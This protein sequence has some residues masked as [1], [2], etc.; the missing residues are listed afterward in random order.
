MCFVSTQFFSPSQGW[1]A[2]PVSPSE[3]Q[4]FLPDSFH[5][6]EELGAIENA[7]FNAGPTLIHIQTAHGNYEAQQK[8]R[9]L[10]HFLKQ[11]YGIKTLFIEGSVSKLEPERLRFFPDDMPLTMKISDDLTKK[12][13]VKGPELF[14]L[15]DKDSEAYG[16]ENA[17]IY[18]AGGQ[19]FLAVLTQQQKTNHFVRAVD[20][21]IDRLAGIV[22]NKDLRAFLKR[23]EE[24]DAGRLPVVE[25]LAALKT[26]AAKRLEM[27]LEDPAYQ[28]DWPMLVRIFKLQEIEKKM[29]LAAYE[30]EK[31]EFLN[32]IRRFMGVGASLA[33]ARSS[34]GRGQA[35]PLPSEIESI[36]ST[37]FSHQP[38]PYPQTEILFEKMVSALPPNF[39]YE[40]YPNV[41]FFI[42]HL[43]LQSEIKADF[44][45]KET[46]A[47]ADKISE[48]LAKTPDEKK[49]LTLL[50]NY[51]LL[52]KLFRLE[53]TPR[54]YET[55]VSFSR[56]INIHMGPGQN[57]VIPAKAGI[58]FGDDEN[59]MKP[60]LI[61]NQF[62]NLNSAKRVRDIRFN[63]L[64]EIDS[65]F[66]KA[67]DYYRFVKERDHWMM[68]NIEK[69]MKEKGIEKAIVITGGFHSQPFTDTFTQK[70]YRYALIS[71]KITT[72]DGREAYI[73][74]ALK[75]GFNLQSSTTET[76]SLMDRA[77]RL[78]LA[79]EQA[80]WQIVK[81]DSPAGR[82]IP[83]SFHLFQSSIDHDLAQALGRSRSGRL[84]MHPALRAN[85]VDSRS[86][87]RM[88]NSL[89]HGEKLKELREQLGM[90]QTEFRQ[91]LEPEN[92][93][94]QGAFSNWEKGKTPVSI[95]IMRKAEDLVRAK[96]GDRLK[97][98]REQLGMTQMEF[99][100]A[101][102]PKNPFS[103]ATVSNWERGV[104]P[105][106]IR[107]MR[108]AEGLVRAKSG[109]RLKD[110][111]EQLG[112]N[113]KEL[114][115]ALR[116]ENAYSAKMVSLWEKG[117]NSVSL[118]VMRKTE[119]LVRA[120]SGDR[121][122]EF[123]E[124][125]GM[126]QTEF[127]QALQPENPPENVSQWEKSKRAIPKEIFLKAEKIMLEKSGDHLKA[128]REQLGMNQKEFGRVLRHENPFLPGTISHWEK[129]G[130]LVPVE[131]VRKAEELVRAKS[132]DR[133]K[134]LREQLGMTQPELGQVLRPEN[135][136]SSATISEWERG[137]APVSI[138]IMRKAEELVRAK[139]GD[140]LEEMR[141]Q[142]GM[143]RTE[144]GQ[145][146]RPE[147]PFSVG[148]IYSW[149]K[150]KT[151]FSIEIMRKAEEL[152]RAKGGDRL[153]EQREQLGMDQT[154]FGRMLR[155]ENPLVFSAV[156]AWE[157]GRN[158]VPI[159]IAQ[160]AEELVRIKSG[161]RLKKLREQLGMTQ[162]EFG[163]A[164]RPENPWA[165]STISILEKGGKSVPIEVIRKAQALAAQQKSRSEARA[166]TEPLDQVLQDYRSETVGTF[167]ALAE[168]EAIPPWSQVL[169]EIVRRL[170]GRLKENHPLNLPTVFAIAGK[171]GAAKTEIAG[172]LQGIFSQD[173]T[174]RAAG[175]ERV[176]NVS[177]DHFRL[178]T[179]DENFKIDKDK[180]IRDVLDELRREY[181]PRLKA[182]EAA[183]PGTVDKGALEKEMHVTLAKF[184][185]FNEKLR[186]LAFQPYDIETG[187][188]ST[189]L[190][191]QFD[192]IWLGIFL[193]NAKMVVSAGKEP[194]E[195]GFFHPIF[196]LRSRGRV[197]LAVSSGGRLRI[198]FRLRDKKLWG[199][200]IK[201]KKTGSWEIVYR[202][203]GRILGPEEVRQKTEYSENNIQV[204]AIRPRTWKGKKMRGY[205]IR[206][207]D[208]VQTVLVPPKGRK[209]YV[210]YEGM[211]APREFSAG[212]LANVLV[213]PHFDPAT[214][215]IFEWM[216]AL[217]I[218][219]RTFDASLFLD[220][221]P[222]VRVGNRL[223]QRF[224]KRE[225]GINLDQFLELQRQAWFIR[226]SLIQQSLEEAR[227]RA[228][229]P[230]SSLVEANTERRKERLFASARRGTLVS[231]EISEAVQAQ[232][233]LHPDDFEEQGF[234][235]KGF[236]AAASI[237]ARLDTIIQETVKG[238]IRKNKYTLR[239]IKP[240]AGPDGI[241]SFSVGDFTFTFRNQQD[242]V[243]KQWELSAKDL[244]HLVE[245]KSRGGQFVNPFLVFDLG[246]WFSPEQQMTLVRPKGRRET[247]RIGKVLVQ[248]RGVWKSSKDQLDLLATD[249]KTAELSGHKQVAAEI[250]K[251]AAQIIRRALENEINLAET[252]YV[253]GN[254]GEM[255]SSK[256]I[257]PEGFP[258]QA[259]LFALQSGAGAY[260]GYRSDAYRGVLENG[261]IPQD[262]KTEYRLLLMEM[263]PEDK[264]GFKDLY[265]PLQLPHAVPTVM[266]AEIAKRWNFYLES[267]MLKSKIRQM[268]K[269]FE[270]HPKSSGPRT[271]L[272]KIRDW[273]YLFKE[274]IVD[275]HFPN[276]PA[277]RAMEYISEG[278]S[279]LSRE[280]DD[281]TGEEKFQAYKKVVFN[282]FQELKDENSLDRLAI[283]AFFDSVPRPFL[284][285][286]AILDYDGVLYT[287]S[288]N[289][290]EIFGTVFRVDGGPAV[291]D[292]LIDR[293]LRE[294]R[295]VREMRAKALT[296][297]GPR[298]ETFTKYIGLLS[299]LFKQMPGVHVKAENIAEGDRARILEDAYLDALEKGERLNPG[300][301]EWVE[302][303]HRK[304]IPFVV[305]SDQYAGTGSDARVLKNL[306][307]DFPGFFD[308]RNVLFSFSDKVQARKQEG[309]HAFSEAVARLGLP[310]SEILLVDDNHRN[311]PK[312]R[313]AG[314]QTFHY[315]H[316][317]HGRLDNALTLELPA[318]R[319]EVRTGKFTPWPE[320][321][322]E[323]EMRLIKRAL[324]K[325]KTQAL[326]AQLL[327]ISRN[328]LT[329]KIKEYGIDLKAIEIEKIKV[330]LTQ[331]RGK[332]SHAARLLESSSETLKK[333][334]AEYQ[335]E[336]FAQEAKKLPKSKS[337]TA[338][339]PL[340][341]TGDVENLNIEAAVA[342]AEK[343]A[344]LKA[345]NEAEGVV[346]S[347]ADIL[348]I[349]RN[350][351]AAKLEKMG[352]LPVPDSSSG[353][354]P[355]SI[356]QASDFS[357]RFWDDVDKA[358]FL[359][360]FQ[361]VGKSTGRVKL[362][363]NMALSLGLHRNSISKRA[364][365]FGIDLSLLPS[366]K[367]NGTPK[368]V[369]VEE[370]R[371]AY[372]I[373]ALILY[374]EKERI[375]IAGKMGIHRNTLTQWIEALKTE[376]QEQ[377]TD[378][379][380][381]SFKDRSFLDLILQYEKEVR[382][383][384]NERE[385]QALFDRIMEETTPE[386]LNDL[387]VQVKLR[388]A[389]EGLGERFVTFVDSFIEIHQQY[390]PL[391]KKVN[392]F[393]EEMARL[394]ETNL[395]QRTQALKAEIDGKKENLQTHLPE[396]LAIFKEASGRTIRQKPYWPQVLAGDCHSSRP[397]H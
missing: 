33:G 20:M 173:E 153:K 71:P 126:T 346:L 171:S 155:P 83:S 169:P 365:D 157:R 68:E 227:Q 291:F 207:R 197:R 111:R 316:H 377:K 6:P 80:I 39:N 223:P 239:E 27:N 127:G 376:Y 323:I 339:V 213:H 255:F 374:K 359:T 116:P 330:A 391:A 119:A 241:V 187:N 236:S 19:A 108:K 21:Q 52:Q 269:N 231:P 267:V 212:R 318:A 358:N 60:S 348:G 302:D 256:E 328:T 294:N 356:P 79:A 299:L 103:L 141:K 186:K 354:S 381:D 245:L 198:I 134:D 174:L 49:I 43:I 271:G 98:F 370:L 23:L 58:H 96:S 306:A 210:L 11:T 93:I 263:M 135:P 161:D 383:A 4:A 9:G 296:G 113:R 166:T 28:I 140:R 349:D 283:E 340:K 56:P 211:K 238:E 107:I 132:G 297:S 204:K 344:I 91:A 89:E 292:T 47:L 105:V 247:G 101:L 279:D 202:E 288:L 350:T 179:P 378:F 326:A 55:I 148:I 192:D 65:L 99:G 287:T 73:D 276:T 143:S 63:H 188:L 270:K 29:D 228:G 24:Y 300:A 321:K 162:T 337:G 226:E 170:A 242:P 194:P 280:H 84:P 38:R 295:D 347:A 312:A 277:Y 3:V 5:I 147:N 333:K 289:W 115:Q 142:L 92:S 10:L 396:A 385:N 357:I 62:L 258:L 41:K 131:I 102:R 373:A 314:L 260:E 273:A 7:S 364:E 331:A 275:S 243:T 305:L 77:T 13:Y 183:T 237:Q 70:G 361:Y 313:E 12:A 209:F 216:L 14:L 351:L 117:I 32:A 159:E 15:E 30:K 298:E 22:M 343:E 284:A 16:I 272:E 252:G 78:G 45:M 149:E 327:G 232:F 94:S 322:K 264:E 178:E 34:P 44:L 303:L 154:E 386:Q 334:I 196:D 165:P 382:F 393:Q 42:G 394:S 220:A 285:R 81:N 164:L 324:Q 222:W 218:E 395:V 254:P 144:F 180:T 379:N 282:Y 128:L 342:P 268:Q 335:L 109:D 129:G 120:K 205:E 193:K 139:S 26:E 362:I 31:K 375:R 35:P 221:D 262:F 191:A 392:D 225:G 384:F 64:E 199:E 355:A 110:L 69:H 380:P 125:S 37:S 371:K 345:M 163:Q 118:E 281:W 309:P 181:L 208:S 307:R 85:H 100:Q 265:I 368:P 203:G 217:K 121:L 146:L 175:L 201:N 133:L 114:G 388:K 317:S 176:V 353:A 219:P 104:A 251:H 130:R 158:P 290:R 145:A 229:S 137:A 150:G 235:D 341:E 18:N 25:W 363:Q 123:R 367:L 308:E 338:D 195:W 36:L 259:D 310:A 172:I 325:A 86:E 74:S 177:G 97:D 206:V 246:S 311:L 17:K 387:E 253:N 87:A 1:S 320:Q 233:Y 122:K 215:V 250:R 301:R 40:L 67:L 138:E 240:A 352:G 214:L 156:S 2:A 59:A 244:A 184:R 124:Q 293:L 360:A 304:G 82:H 372:L 369:P 160:K 151:P 54:E 152:V 389:A 390:E 261:D 57:A 88:K 266:T 224:I 48:K 230:S 286:G 95:E 248:A 329:A 190:V 319:A 76:M 249:L 315:E 257:S 106:S 53:L 51:R 200:V 189:N 397:R 332:I 112:M 167:A 274:G 46:E 234:S 61:I 90:T 72:L 75:M 8:I 50:K 182:Y 168:G 66:N 366:G 136:F 278:L 185:Q 336:E